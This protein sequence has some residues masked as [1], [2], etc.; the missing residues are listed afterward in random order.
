MTNK[1]QVETVPQV[2]SRKMAKLV[3]GIFFDLIGMVSYAVPALAEIIDVVWAPVSAILLAS[4][5]KGTV[6]KAAGAFEFLEEILPGTDIIPTFTLTWIYTYV[7][8]KEK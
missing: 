1:V 3:L 8:K 4:M 6:G 2:K 7:I 5:Y